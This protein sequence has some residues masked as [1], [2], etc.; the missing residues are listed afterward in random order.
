MS[1]KTHIKISLALL[2]ESPFYN[3]SDDDLRK[4]L[5]LYIG[6]SRVR[7][8]IEDIEDLVN[9]RERYQLIGFCTEIA[10]E[11]NLNLSVIFK[12]LSIVPKSS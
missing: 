10:Q 7:H 9:S 8:L 5:T 12:T 4:F 2:K 6:V 3:L 1:N 11:F